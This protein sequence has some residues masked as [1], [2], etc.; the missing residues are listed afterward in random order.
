MASEG[1]RAAVHNAAQNDLQLAL[2]GVGG[3]LVG[4]IAALLG[5]NGRMISYG[6]LDGRPADLAVFLPKA[7]SL[8]GVTIGTWNA[9]TAPDV[10]AQDMRQAIEIGRTTPA[11]FADFREFEL[12]E[13]LDAINAVTAPGKSGNV[14]LKFQ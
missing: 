14:I 5:T 8:I 6:L 4:E 10:R 2:D 11:I 13:L 12:S 7:L 1:W 3:S 9:E